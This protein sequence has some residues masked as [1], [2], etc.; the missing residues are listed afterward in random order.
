MGVTYRGLHV[1]LSADA[2]GLVGAL[3]SA[4]R[5]AAAATVNLR[6]LDQ[7]LKADPKN[8]ALLS[9]RMA[10]YKAAIRA[11][12]AEIKALQ[13]YEA[14]LAGK[15]SAGD[16]GAE[17]MRAYEAEL[18]K[19]R[20]ELAKSTQRLDSYKEALSKAQVEQAAM[21]LRLGRMGSAVE[22]FGDRVGASAQRMSSIGSTMTRTVSLGVVAASAATVAAAVDIDTSLTNVRKTVD[23]TA[24]QYERLKQ[25]ALEFSR[26]N[27]VEASD[28][29]DADA[30]GAQLGFAITELDEFSRVV[31]SLSLSTDMGTEQAGTEMARFANITKM[32]HSDISNYGSA[33]VGLGNSFATTE[34]EISAL[35]MRL[36]AA[37]TQVGMSQADI[38]GL[39]TALSSM[40]VEAEAGGTAMSTI[41]ANI[42]K[43]VATG[44]SS[45]GEWA[46][47]A[48]MSAGEFAAAWKGDPVAA[49]A[50]VLSGME[51]ATEGGGNM[52][53][54]LDDLGVS[55]LRQTDTL[56][57]LAGNSEFVAEAVAVANREWR[58]NTALQAEVDNRNQS[59][60][61]KFQM[62]RNRAVE[63]AEA[64]GG[65]MADALLDIVDAA[66]PAVDALAS[67]AK[68][69][70]DL[71]EGAQR[72]LLAL[73]G[74]A[75]AM[76]PL[77][78]VTG[79]TLSAAKPLGQAMQSLARAFARAR[80]AGKQAA[81]GIELAGS[82]AKS[83]IS[84]AKAASGA[85]V[86]LGA[87]VLAIS[88]ATLASELARAEERARNLDKATDG[89]RGTVGA[90]AASLSRGAGAAM[91]YAGSLDAATAAVDALLEGQARLADEM[92]EREAAV[93]SEAALLGEYGEVIARLAGRSDL[94]AEAQAELT[95]AVEGVNGA[96]GTSY[97][98]ARDAEGAFV[99]MGDGAEVAAGQIRDLIAAQQAQIAFDVSKQGYE[100]A[101]AQQEEGARALAEAQSALA[102]AQADY[103]E[104]I[105]AGVLPSYL[106]AEAGAIAELQA[107]VA[108]ASG[109]FE[110]AGATADYYHERMTLCTMATQASAD[111]ITRFV[112]GSMSVQA[113]V[114]QSG[115]SLLD[116][117]AQL[118][119]TGASVEQLGALSAEQLTA[120]GANYDGTMQSIV[121][122]LQ[123]F[124]VQTGPLGAEAG[125]SWAG[126]LA[127]KAQEA[128][129]RAAEV[130]G[131]T[132][133]ELRALAEGAG[134][135]GDEAM[136]AFCSAVE[137]HGGDAEA[138]A[139]SVAEQGRGGLDV[140]TETAGG[141]F[142]SG[143]ARG[144]EA[145]VGRVAA[146]AARMA[147]AAVAAA[148]AAQDSGSPSRVM[149]EKGDDFD[150]GYELGIERSSS[151]PERAAA[152]MTE[153]VLEAGGSAAEG[154]W[155]HGYHAAVNY[156]KGLKAGSKA[157]SASL[158]SSD[159]EFQAYVDSMIAS[160][161]KRIPEAEEASA[162][163]SEALWGS[164]APGIMAKG[165]LEPATGAVYDSVRAIKGAG[166][167]LE[168]YARK[169]Q[170]W[171]DKCAEG[172]D[173][174]SDST[175]AEYEE[176]QRL[177]GQVGSS[178][179]EIEEWWDLAS[180][181]ADIIDGQRAADG[182]SDALA[183]LRGRGIAVSESFAKAFAEGGDEYRSVLLGMVDMTDEA[184]QE[185]ADAYEDMARAER[186]QAIE[187][188]SLWVNSLATLRGEGRD[189]RDLLM[190]FRETALDVKEAVY[191]DEGL[192]AAFLA[193]GVSI[194]GFA[195]DL[196]AL[197]VSMEGFVS[198]MGSYV[199]S[200]SNGFAQMT[201]YNQT[202]LADW[203]RNLQLN[204]A[205][206]QQWAANLESVFAKVDGL[207]VDSEAFRKAVW[208]GGFSQ[209]GAVMADMAGMTA[210]QI[211]GVIDLYNQSILEGQTAALEAFQAI[212]PGEEVMNAMI[213]GVMAS[214]EGVRDASAGTALAGAE[215]AASAEPE[216]YATGQQLASG[217]EAGI[218][219]KVQAIAAA[220]AAAVRAAIEAAKAEADIA[221]PSRRMRREVGRMLGLG[222]A[223]GI[224]DEQGE[225][226]SA[227][228]GLVKASEAKARAQV[229]AMPEASY[230]S[231]ARGGSV[232]NVRNSQ[233]TMVVE[234]GGVTVRS[235]DDYR[236]LLRDLDR[237]QRRAMRAEGAL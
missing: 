44:S 116:F 134:V 92:A 67:G 72:A 235:E 71:D 210:E 236:R 18:V 141:E 137:A 184:A 31:T 68:A 70:A 15:M 95:A 56:K 59:L 98:V 112:A 88:L 124:G 75:A 64:V 3:K 209:W 102:A 22:A 99:V 108:A 198:K 196:M 79:K 62:V 28:I 83:A 225:V 212:S 20:S 5:E 77:L 118:A 160:Y 129:A 41:M 130:A 135:A 183:N 181:K 214:E 145:G 4:K 170:E 237:L 55:S 231:L 14:E 192:S 19:V 104:K 120:L 11:T 97:E 218:R 111:A 216:Y 23:G 58:D 224:G 69:F 101:Y 10:D 233:V 45:L 35:A 7:A 143:F 96:C 52:S 12:E 85:F 90:G 74:L 138:A 106:T 80:G 38:L 167:D 149:A 117:R 156:S 133:A 27:G 165:W 86:A 25:K 201:K 53:L 1:E 126:R 47:A 197:D 43:A 227:M 121:A 131:M 9:Q 190:D 128:V 164:V 142:S 57:R 100:D 2:K 180:V 30:L 144:I 187:Q 163:F 65:P 39:A 8:A 93:A 139:R 152:A 223:Y 222:V 175:K 172:M 40:G 204:M 24:E 174:W 189:A 178:M 206:S 215:A 182:L 161:R 94:T 132:E 66:E 122:T 103:D 229:V 76:G 155:V 51:A 185:I 188:R 89:L 232:S 60:A 159:A 193:A 226:A 153:R 234:M 194:D 110:A 220:A 91:G 87:A 169:Q 140:D 150:W 147:Q 146:A 202:S 199:S 17:D 26:T 46:S 21:G 211:Q 119:D 115:Q 200:V 186:L 6:T 50:A 125:E 148:Q 114:Q 113:G 173:K 191:S 49:L 207:A 78:S 228:A 123:S 195:A 29:L 13:G 179:G 166:Y 107:Q 171:A 158:G 157:S 84:P 34:S 37:G 32:A 168:G 219:S 213:E 205:E 33:V 217:I 221:S 203:Q 208:E 136:V 162:A 82:A 127:E 176:W 73:V 36:A 54:M 63:I 154:M 230:A 61:A 151:R 109:A 16:V 177:Q 48:K 81:E 105:S 42:D